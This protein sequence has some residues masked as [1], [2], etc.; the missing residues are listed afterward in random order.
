[1]LVQMAKKQI[2]KLCDTRFVGLITTN[3]QSNVCH[4]TVSHHHM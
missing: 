1:M 2:H 4:Q 3:G